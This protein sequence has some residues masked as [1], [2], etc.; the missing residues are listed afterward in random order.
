MLRVAWKPLCDAGNFLMGEPSPHVYAQ[1]SIV[2]C[3]LLF[4]STEYM[5]PIYIPHHGF[6]NFGDVS[7]AEDFVKIF[8]GM[9]LQRY[10][11]SKVIAASPALTQGL[12]ANIAQYTCKDAQRIQNPWFRPLI[13]KDGDLQ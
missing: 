2:V 8:H 13:F 12:E 10:T 6:V 11:T 4:F 1:R 3:Q 7:A 5:Q 9:Q